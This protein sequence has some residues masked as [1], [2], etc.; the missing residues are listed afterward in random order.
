[1]K[2]VYIPARWLYSQYLGL[3]QNDILIRRSF[4]ESGM[5]GIV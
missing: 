2:N 4:C 1:M 5:L 3:R